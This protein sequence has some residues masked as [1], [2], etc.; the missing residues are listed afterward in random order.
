MKIDDIC[1]RTTSY[2]RW[3]AYFS[4]FSLLRTHVFYA[5][6]ACMA[7][8]ALQHLFGFITNSVFYAEFFIIIQD[9]PNVFLSNYNC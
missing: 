4:R 3:D 1:R 7:F 2:L 8:V 9:S 6:L 5:M